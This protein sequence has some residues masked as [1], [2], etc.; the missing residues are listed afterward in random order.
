MCNDK[1]YDIAKEVVKQIADKT[2]DDLIHPSAYATGQ[3]VS[4]I[5]RIVKVWLKDLE[6]WILN[7]EYAI[8]EIEVLMEEK[9]KNIP[10]EKIVDPEPY[11]AVPA[12]QQL[13]YSFDSE[14]LRE[15]YAN[16]LVSSM[17]IDKKDNVHPAFVDIIKQLTPCEAKLLSCIYNNQLKGICLKS[18]KIYIVTSTVDVKYHSTE[19]NYAIKNSKHESLNYIVSLEKH[20]LQICLDN[21]ERLGLLKTMPPFDN[22]IDGKSEDSH[23]YELTSFS[24]SFCETCIPSFIEQA[25][26]TVS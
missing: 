26:K 3:I 13:S 19:I 18:E 22:N 10:E 9:L 14:E 24:K 16:L 6:K 15:L 12:I 25:N 17:N 23:Y 8:K 4:F 21:L 11:V 20:I 7:G 1:K 5:P 2:Y